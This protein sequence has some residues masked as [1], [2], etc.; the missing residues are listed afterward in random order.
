MT[1]V[2][3][4]ILLLVV[5]PERNKSL[6]TSWLRLALIFTFALVILIDALLDLVVQ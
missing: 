1:Y 6:V 2:A 4:I 3:V 5:L